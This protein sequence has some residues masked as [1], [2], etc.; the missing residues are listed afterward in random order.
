MDLFDGRTTPEAL[1]PED[2]RVLRM[3]QG[4]TQW[5]RAVLCTLARRGVAFR[6]EHPDRARQILESLS[7]SPLYKGGQFL[8]DLLEWEDFMIDGAPPKILPTVLDVTSLNRI[9]TLL[10]R[11]FH[12][13][14][15]HPAESERL[16][17]DTNAQPGS[18]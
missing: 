4:G 16:K 1:E 9:A 10:N 18:F 5:L 11:A 13:I 8:F 2:V 7:A 15:D 6:Q 12:F 3:V 14:Y 17:I